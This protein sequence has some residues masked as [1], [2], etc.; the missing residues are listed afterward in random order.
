MKCCSS[1]FW[2]SYSVTLQLPRLYDRVVVTN[3]LETFRS[4]LDQP[5]AIGKLRFAVSGF[6][7]NGLPIFGCLKT[8]LLMPLLFA[9]EETLSRFLFWKPSSY[10]ASIPWS[11]NGRINGLPLYYEIRRYV[12]SLN[13]TA[14]WT[15]IY[16]EFF[17]FIDLVHVLNVTFEIPKEVNRKSFT[18]ATTER[19]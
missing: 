11:N 17:E 16:P 13:W 14:S 1:V 8:S 9:N 4:R 5:S 3:T 18:F 19:V 10:T 2:P 6:H 12:P 7:V 15:W